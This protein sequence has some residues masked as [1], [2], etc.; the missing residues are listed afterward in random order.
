MTPSSD[1]AV[2]ASVASSFCRSSAAL[3]SGCVPR[4][5]APG[6]A[7]ARMP[8]IATASTGRM[9]GRDADGN[10]RHVVIRWGVAAPFMDGFEDGLDHRRRREITT[11]AHD[12]EEPRRGELLRFGVHR[13]EHTVGA[14]DEEVVL[15]EGEGDLVVGRSLERTQ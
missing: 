1:A 4:S 13:L 3:G 2:R 11:A 6:A 10:R 5:C 14:E 15:V 7:M 9:S 12:L 8:A